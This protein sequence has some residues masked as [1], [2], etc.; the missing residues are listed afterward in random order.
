MNRVVC[1]HCH[2]RPIGEGKR[3][4]C[5]EHSRQASA[6]WK[7]EHRRLWRSMGDKYWLSDWKNKTSE[8]RKA[9]FRA[10]MREYRKRNLGKKNLKA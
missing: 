2:V 7:R 10:Y 4:Y 5:E 1:I 9:Y 8:E 6:I 3:K